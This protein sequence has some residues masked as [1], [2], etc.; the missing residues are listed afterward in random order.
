MLGKTAF[1]GVEGA[2]CH[3]SEARAK[4]EGWSC[5]LTC[6]GVVGSLV[7]TKAEGSGWRAGG[8]LPEKWGL[9]WKSPQNP[10]PPQ[11]LKHRL[12]DTMVSSFH[13]ASGWAEQVWR[14]EV[15]TRAGSAEPPSLFLLQSLLC[16]GTTNLLLLEGQGACPAPLFLQHVICASQ[17]LALR[18]GGK[19]ANFQLC[20]LSSLAWKS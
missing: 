17:T 11:T 12:L 6:R 14:L 15:G 19:A 7:C 20:S 3:L 10:L 13:S 2:G 16:V 9:L 8:I 4:Q 1:T 5:Q 18:G